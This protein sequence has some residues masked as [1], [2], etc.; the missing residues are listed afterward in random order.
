MADIGE[1]IGQARALIV[2]ARAADTSALR[3]QADALRDDVEELLFEGEHLEACGLLSDALASV[4]LWA[5][6][7]DRG[8]VDRAG[9]YL[10]QA[11]LFAD[12]AHQSLLGN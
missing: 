2:G 5:R 6:A 10:E 7:R 9:D 1:V 11:G 12:A 4:L 3:S 8:D